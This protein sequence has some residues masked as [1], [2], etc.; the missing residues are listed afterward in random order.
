MSKNS[1][2]KKATALLLCGVAALSMAACG[3]GFR[4]DDSSEEYDPTKTYLNVGNY[5]GGLGYAWLREVADKYEAAHPDVKIKINNEKDKYMDATLLEQM[6]NY[7]NDMYFV[8]AITYQT[9]VARGKVA[10]ITDV[11]TE[12]IEGESESIEDKMNA[13]LREYYKTNDGKYYAVPFFDGI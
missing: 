13:T 11:V 10:D 7:G 2:A 3:G 8:N 12:N 1:M 9:Y 5:N 4:R 6:A